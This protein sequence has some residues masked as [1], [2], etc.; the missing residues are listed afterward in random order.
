[1]T[2]ILGFHPQENS[3]VATT[4]LESWLNNRDYKI[5]AATTGSASNSSLKVGVKGGSKEVRFEDDLGWVPIRC[6]TGRARKEVLA[7]LDQLDIEGFMFAGEV[8]HVARHFELE[9]LG[10][11]TER[12]GIVESAELS[13]YPFRFVELRRGRRLIAKMLVGYFN[14]EMTEAAPT[15]ELLEVVKEDRGKG[16]GSAIIRYAEEVAV[17]EGF[18]RIWGTDAEQSLGLLLSL[19]YQQDLEECVKFF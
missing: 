12:V 11:V 4:S 19:G 2:F 15:M 17:D 7:W 16:I 14:R 9:G 6:K 10:S 13:L 18:D 8:V 3:Q 1:M 5:E